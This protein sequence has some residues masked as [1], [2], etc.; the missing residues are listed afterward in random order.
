VRVAEL[1]E[2]KVGDEKEESLYFQRR[3]L[4]CIHCFEAETRMPKVPESSR[5]RIMTMTT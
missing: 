2:S 5:K 1:Q 4:V 3:R